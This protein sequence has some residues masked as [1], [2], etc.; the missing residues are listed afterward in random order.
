MSKITYGDLTAK[1]VIEI[2]KIKETI[3]KSYNDTVNDLI[4]KRYSVSEE[5]AILRQR[6]TK[7]QEFEEYN[8]YCEECKRR[9]KS[10]ILG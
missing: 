6:D 4:R 1:D 8:R 9:A 3:V 10:V 5:F 7:S 2:E